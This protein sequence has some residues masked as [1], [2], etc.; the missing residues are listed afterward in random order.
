MALERGRFRSVDVEG[1]G[2]HD[3]RQVSGEIFKGCGHWSSP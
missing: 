3:V 2:G 1:L